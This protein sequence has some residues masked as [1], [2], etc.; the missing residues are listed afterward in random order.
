[1]DTTEWGV[2]DPREDYI[3]PFKGFRVGDKVG[4]LR[5]SFNVIYPNPKIRFN[6]N[7]REE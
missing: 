5:I 6:L 2:I 1:M 7:R 4:R 3:I